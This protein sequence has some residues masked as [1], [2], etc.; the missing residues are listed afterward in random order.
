MSHSAENLL[1]ELLQKS[2]KLKRKAL[3]KKMLLARKSVRKMKVPNGFFFFKS[4]MTP[5]K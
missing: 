2:M 4:S 3:K 1:E 5:V